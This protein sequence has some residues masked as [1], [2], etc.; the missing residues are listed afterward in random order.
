LGDGEK[1]AVY[2]HLALA[3]AGCAGN[4]LGARSCT[5][6]FTGRA[7]N[8][9][10][11]GNFLFAAAHGFEKIDFQIVA[12]IGALVGSST[13]A[14]S[15]CSAECTFKNVAKDATPH[16]TGAEDFTEDF[17]GIVKTATSHSGARRESA[18]AKTVVGIAFLLVGKNFVGFPNLFELFLGFLIALVFVGMVLNSEFPVG[19]FDVF[20]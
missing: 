5:T 18:V 12:K 11:K 13:P 6:T 7:R 19:L 1:A 10:A 8:G 3:A 9:P 14:A 16:T 15:A 2:R 17:E 20:R 4:H